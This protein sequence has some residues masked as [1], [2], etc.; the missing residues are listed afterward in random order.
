M[1]RFEQFQ[2]VFED[3]SD[4]KLIPT[5]KSVIIKDASKYGYIGEI[6]VYRKAMISEV[7][8]QSPAIVAGWLVTETLKAPGC[9]DGFVISVKA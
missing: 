4:S 1:K 6:L 2:R 8:P 3:T 5:R 7:Q 9:L